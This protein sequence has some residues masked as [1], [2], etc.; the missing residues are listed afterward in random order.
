M[1]GPRAL[2]RLRHQPQTT[3]RKFEEPLKIE[4]LGDSPH[5]S[6]A[7]DTA[8]T[9]EDPCRLTDSHQLAIETVNPKLQPWG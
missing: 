8:Q 2:N 9:V 4:F 7:V 1:P 5:R 3:P 6:A